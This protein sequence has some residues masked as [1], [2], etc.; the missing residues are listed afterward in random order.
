[1]ILL[2]LAEHHHVVDARRLGQ[3]LAAVDLG[4]STTAGALLAMATRETT[5]STALEA[6]LTH[7]RPLAVPEPL[8]PVMARHPGL[9]A[10]VK[11]SR[12]PLGKAAISS[13]TLAT[14][15]PT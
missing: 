11:A 8:F 6:A 12:E 2:W 3:R 13:I 10:L 15:M 5:G 14:S 7:C 1:M 9:L 4:T